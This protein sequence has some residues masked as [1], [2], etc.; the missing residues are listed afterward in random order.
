MSIITFV[1]EYQDG[2]EP[3]ISAGMTYLDGVI[4][5]A[6]FSDLHQEVDRLEERISELEQVIAEMD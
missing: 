3:S 5:S 6:S 1:F 4:V 2:L